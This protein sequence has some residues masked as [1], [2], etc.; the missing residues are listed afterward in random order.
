VRHNVSIQL[1]I[2]F[3][4][5]KIQLRAKPYV[6][7]LQMPWLSDEKHL[8]PSVAYSTA[9]SKYYKGESWGAKIQLMGPTDFLFRQIIN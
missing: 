1:A 9:Q 8:P 2:Y 3:L 4:S 6:F 5:E 7:R